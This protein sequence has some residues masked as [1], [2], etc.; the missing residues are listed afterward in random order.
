MNRIVVA[1]KK[2]PYSWVCAKIHKKQFGQQT[3]VCQSFSKHFFYD[4]AFDPGY[5]TTI[6]E[7]G[8]G[9]SIP[10]RIPLLGNRNGVNLALQGLKWRKIN[11][12]LLSWV[13][14][15]VLRVPTP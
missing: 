4:M 5:L 13:L 15:P 11:L 2:E 3:N 10:N 6:R 1:Q 7:D 8:N 14:I 9:V 12:H